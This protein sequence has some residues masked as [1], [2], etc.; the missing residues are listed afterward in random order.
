M[1]NF[2]KAKKQGEVLGGNEL[3]GQGGKTGEGALVY[4]LK[5]TYNIGLTKTPMFISTKDIG[6]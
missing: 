2:A 3:F 5:Q 4:F 1:G 6:R